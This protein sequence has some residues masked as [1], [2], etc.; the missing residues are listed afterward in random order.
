M[1]PPRGWFYRWWLCISGFGERS[2]IFEL[3]VWLISSGKVRSRELLSTSEKPNT[4]LHTNLMAGE[5]MKS[6]NYRRQWGLREIQVERVEDCQTFF[7]S[8][9][10][11]LFVLLKRSPM[12]IMLQ[13][14]SNSKYII[15]RR[16]WFSQYHPQTQLMAVE[17]VSKYH[18]NHYKSLQTAPNFLKSKTGS[19]SCLRLRVDKNI[20]FIYFKF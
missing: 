16:N 12:G 8:F 6:P 20:F 15:L 1:I 19:N 10:V 17:S 5:K 18:I 2:P 13:A 4:W 7:F 11:K 3:G 9:F 14:G